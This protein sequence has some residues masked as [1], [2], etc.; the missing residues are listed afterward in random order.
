[1]RDLYQAGV[2]GNY[3]K[4]QNGNRP[5]H[6]WYFRGDETLLREQDIQIHRIFQAVLS[7]VHPKD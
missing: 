2:I 3:T 5:A 1:M 4:A 7:T 6:R